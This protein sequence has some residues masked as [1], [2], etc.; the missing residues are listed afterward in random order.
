MPDPPDPV[1]HLPHGEQVGAGQKPERLRPIQRLSFFN[2]PLD[3]FQHSMQISAWVKSKA[4]FTRIT[5][6]KF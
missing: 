2:F 6:D 4:F 5:S 1:G 3:L